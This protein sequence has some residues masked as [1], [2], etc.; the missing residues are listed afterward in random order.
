METTDEN[1]GGSMSETIV[2]GVDGS[3]DSLDALGSA[4]ELAGESGARLVVIHV[5]H[6][7]GLASLGGVAGGT[8]AL[9]EALDQL[10]EQTRQSVS[11]ALVGRDV[12]WQFDVASG[13]PAHELIAAAHDQHAAA[14]VVG[15]RHHG[16]VGGL[17]AGSVAQK[18]IRHAPVSVLVVRDSHA[19]RVATKPA[20]RSSRVV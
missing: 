14:I 1:G 3:A 4:A 20:V 18:L 8:A 5:R 16:V 6:E 7:S 13:D 17:I 10:E 19:H 15:G 12:P 9:S 11:D 2:V